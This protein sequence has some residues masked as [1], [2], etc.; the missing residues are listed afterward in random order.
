M[1]LRSVLVGFL[2]GVIYA[3][4]YTTAVV[5][6]V[7]GSSQTYMFG[8]LVQTVEGHVRTSVVSMTP[9]NALVGGVIS[10]VFTLL[11]LVVWPMVERAV[12]A[13]G[14][15]ISALRENQERI[16]KSDAAK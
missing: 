5:D 3:S 15:W 6:W 10:F 16:T 14:S 11:G 1:F 9:F 2:M 7:W 12:M 13:V 4:A 8:S